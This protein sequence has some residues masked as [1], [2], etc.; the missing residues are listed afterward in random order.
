MGHQ[1]TILAAPGDRLSSARSSRS[2]LIRPVASAA[3]CQVAI[4]SFDETNLSNA[5]KIPVKTTAR[6]ITKMM[7]P[8][9]AE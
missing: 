2:V 8:E 5:R 4:S 9:I 3:H 1:E 6:I 7:P